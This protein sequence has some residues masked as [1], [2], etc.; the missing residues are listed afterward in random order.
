[1]AECC[2]TYFILKCFEWGKLF[3]D[4]RK[5]YVNSP[6]KIKQSVKQIHLVENEKKILKNNLMILKKNQ[7]NEQMNFIF[8]YLKNHSNQ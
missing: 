3:R 4:R 5:S 1:M 8:P 2:Q 7:L 6:N